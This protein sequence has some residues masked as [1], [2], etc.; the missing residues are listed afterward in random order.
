[1]RPCNSENTGLSFRYLLLHFLTLFYFFLSFS[2]LISN[3]SYSQKKSQ[4]KKM[5]L[6]ITS[7][8]F[9]NGDNIPVKYTCEGSNVSPPLKWTNNIQGVKTYVL[10][11]DDPDA[12]GGDFVHWLAYNIPANYSSLS[13]DVTTTRNIPDEVHQGTNS[14][15]RI[16]Y[17]GPCP[18]P[19]NAHHYYFKIY[20]LNT[21]IKYESGAEKHQ[22]LKA[23]QGHIIA[24]G[25]LMGKFK[26]EK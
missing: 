14:F 22:L 13:E 7:S 12:P 21:A 10:I 9:K 6:K 25:Q 15:G 11:V 4:V 5:E 17:K 20:A 3:K 2:F 18:P 26:R 1:M 8:A 16:G 23:M 24:E 19:G